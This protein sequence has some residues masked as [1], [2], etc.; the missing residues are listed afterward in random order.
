MA[1]MTSA[2]IVDAAVTPNEDEARQWLTD[3]LAKTPYME[4]QPGPLELFWRAVL[5]W[6]TDALDGVRSLDSDVGV[7]LL[8]FAALTVIGLAI[9]FIKPRLNAAARLPVEV[10]A[11]NGVLE[12]SRHRSL[13]AAAAG[14][15][16]YDEA[17][18]ELLRAVIRSAEERALIERAPGRTAAE[19]SGL[20]GA[21]FPDCTQDIQWLVSRFNEVRYGGR[22][23]SA[24]DYERGR[25]VDQLLDKAPARSR[26]SVPSVFAV[27]S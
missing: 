13:A 21:C 6:L 16:R 17:L 25:T 15:G 4:S 8:G 9:W 1:A 27:P 26:L 24:K 19:V 18:T 14:D 22:F 7:L 20:L 2:Y 12:A 11:G 23:A 5:E 3:E 10:F